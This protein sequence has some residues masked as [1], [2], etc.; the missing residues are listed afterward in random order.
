[1]NTDPTLHFVTVASQPHHGLDR[2]LRSAEHHGLKLQVLGLGQPYLGNGTKILRIAELASTLDPRDWVVYTDAYDSVM[3]ADMGGFR[4]AIE[5][6]DGDLIFSAEQNFHLKGHPLFYLWQNWPI[7]WNYPRVQTPYRF[8]NAGSFLGRAGRLATLN[9][10]LAIQAETS[11]D[12]SVISRYY[13]RNPARLRLD[14]EQRLMTCNGGRI[15]LEKEDYCWLDG[16]LR[17]NLTG[18][19][20]CILHVPGKNEVSIKSILADSPF[21]DRTPSSSRDLHLFAKRARNHRL[22]QAT[23]RDNFLFKILTKTALVLLV[24]T[25][26]IIS[27]SHL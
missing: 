18:H 7:Y 13:C 19:F 16:R 15:G 14:Q 17:N 24:L 26:L 4:A 6:L 10:E 23:T 9:E 2:L 21:P 12:Q 1:M 5:K 8:L 22:V 27:L 25:A 20:P 11:S 3:L